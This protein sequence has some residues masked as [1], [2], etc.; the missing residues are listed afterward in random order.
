MEHQGL[1]NLAERTQGVRSLNVA[2]VLHL[3]ITCLMPSATA[4]AADALPLLSLHAPRYASDVYEAECKV[5]GKHVALKVSC[6]KQR[7]PQG[8]GNPHRRSRCMATHA[9]TCKVAS[10]PLSDVLQRMQ[11]PVVMAPTSS[12]C[13][14][15]TLTQAYVLENMEDIPRVQLAREIRLHSMCHHAN[16]V[17]FYAAFVVS[18]QRVMSD[19]R[20]MIASSGGERW[21]SVSSEWSAGRPGCAAAQPAA[22]HNRTLPR[23]Q[24]TH[25]DPELQPQAVK[26]GHCFAA[27]SAPSPK[28]EVC[29]GN[30]TQQFAENSGPHPHTPVSAA[31][32][33]GERKNSGPRCQ[34][35]KGKVRT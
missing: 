28:A 13:V 16:I 22:G 7:Q 12:P 20:V 23:P 2:L 4:A 6:C 21:Q 31:P 24:K 9:C 15:A 3:T 34:L 35:S 8:N 29:T 25:R 1:R 32:A 18:G 10:S 17:Q 5:T 26:K 33:R 14:L 19:E 11:H 27:P 30:R